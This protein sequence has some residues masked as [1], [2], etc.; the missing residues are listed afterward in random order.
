[1]LHRAGLMRGRFCRGTARGAPHLPFHW[2][3]GRSLPGTDALGRRRI[4]SEGARQILEDV[5]AECLVCKVLVYGLAQPAQ[6][7]I[8]HLQQVLFGLPPAL[9]DG[10]QLRLGRR[11]ERQA[12]A[13][14]C[15]ERLAHY[16]GP[17]LRRAVHYHEGPLELLLH[18]FGSEYIWFCLT[19]HGR[20]TPC[21]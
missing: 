12:Y 3:I 8:G 2:N 20:W 15:P 9:L 21:T 7:D 4:A 6:G 11:K 5:Q 19:A 16:F 17:V 13:G 14:H 1:M 18:L 10:A